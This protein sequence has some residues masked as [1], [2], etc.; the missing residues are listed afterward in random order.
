[1]KIIDA[2][3]HLCHEP[4]GIDAL[5]ESGVFEQ[6][7]LMDLSGVGSLGSLRFAE[8]KELLRT[9]RNYPGFFLAFGYIDLDHARPDEVSRLRDLGFCGLKP[10][11]QLRPY[12]HEIYFPLYA[13]AQE[14]GMPILFHTGLIA[15]GTPYDGRVTHAFGPENMRPVHLAGVA[16]AFPEL[17]ILAGHQ[18]YPYLEE[19]EHNLYYYKNICGD[20]SGYLRSVPRLNEIL[21]RRAHDGT[22]RF[23][24]EKLL[25]ATDEFYGN[26]ASNA[27]ALRLAKFWESYF[28]F[29][30]G[31]YYRWGLP[32][33]Q[34]K[35]FHGNAE[36]LRARFLSQ[37][38]S[39]R[40]FH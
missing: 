16:E 19:M 12:S 18:G 31:L 30:G 6:I 20:I 26:E 39:L 8:Q 5:V 27:R 22:D 35:F 34:E 25:F 3:A 11:K 4:E 9:V 24:N 1:M 15:Q 28:E 38:K 29:I 17:I 21:D 40:E 32:E 2:H 37:K 10:Y 7:W 23:F 13:R 33:E 36:R 14:L